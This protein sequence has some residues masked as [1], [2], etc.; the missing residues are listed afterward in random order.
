[1]FNPFSYFYRLY[2]FFYNLVPFKDKKVTMKVEGD[3]LRVNIIA[4][5]EVKI[6]KIHFDFTQV[7]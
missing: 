7:T 5:P 4:K 2:R 3:T 6:D 1:M